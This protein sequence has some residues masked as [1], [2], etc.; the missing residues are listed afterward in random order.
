MLQIGAY[1]GA[2][3]LGNAVGRRVG[4]CDGLQTALQRT[5]GCKTVWDNMLEK[6][7]IRHIA[8]M[9]EWHKPER[10]PTMDITFPICQ[11]QLEV[12]QLD[13][14]CITKRLPSA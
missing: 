13:V 9:E 10:E 1:E 12:L 4:S 8:T 6:L 14:S 3:E 5:T 7:Q 11:F 2:A